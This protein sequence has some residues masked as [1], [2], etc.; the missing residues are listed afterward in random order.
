MTDQIIAEANH[1]IYVKAKPEDADACS[2]VFYDEN[3]FA[4]YYY[5]LPTLPDDHVRVR[6]LYAGL[7]HSDSLTGRGKWGAKAYPV[8]TGHENIAEVIAVGKAVTSLKIGDKVGLGPFRDSCKNCE[9]CSCGSTHLCQKMD[10]EEKQIYGKYFGGYSTH[11]QHP[12][13]LCFKLPEKLNLKEAA[14]LLCAGVTLFSPMDL[15]LKKGMRIGILGIG[16][17]GHLG[18]Q[19][20]YKMGMTV[21]AFVSGT[22]DEAKN[23]FIKGLGAT[24]IHHW[25]EKGVL[26]QNAG[27]YDALIYTIPVAVEADVMD[28]ILGLLKPRGILI[29]VGAPPVGQNLSLGFFS[30]IASEITIV[31]SMVGGRKETDKMLNFCADN[32]VVS[33]NEHFEWDQFPQALDKLENGSP[34]FRCV[35]NVDNFSKNFGTKN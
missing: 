28:Q 3:T 26:Y 10:G 7:C 35:V 15:H 4:K 12:A 5:K 25:K 13:H 27:K 20:G 6:N 2:W 29:V 24:D 14:P 8:C 34:K 33:L 16:G 21:D 9:W 32:G 22:K 31:G 23:N 19:I 17:L 1:E 18:V 11:L 30:I